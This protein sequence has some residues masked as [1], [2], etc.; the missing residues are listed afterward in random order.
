MCFECGRISFSINI[1]LAACTACARQPLF[2]YDGVVAY[3]TAFRSFHSSP[4]RRY[5]RCC[6]L[7]VFYMYHKNSR[8]LFFPYFLGFINIRCCLSAARS[9]K[10]TYMCP[11]HAHSPVSEQ[12]ARPGVMKK[13]QTSTC[14]RA[15]I[16]MVEGIIV[17]TDVRN[18]SSLIPGMVHSLYRASIFFRTERG[19][20]ILAFI[21]GVFPVDSS[22]TRAACAEVASAIHCSYS[23][24]PRINQTRHFT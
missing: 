3:N 7:C 22:S 17:F 2:I 4:R 6:A 11:H 10:F 18:A 5:C 12:V 19:L 20:V 16:C 1:F 23:Q 15:I 9:V 21:L 8:I 14:M 24:S 13:Q